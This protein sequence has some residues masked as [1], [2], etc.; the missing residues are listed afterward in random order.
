MGKQKKRENKQIP[1]AMANKDTNKITSRSLFMIGE[2]WMEKKSSLLFAIISILSLVFSLLLFNVRISEGG[3]D[4]TYIE[5]GYKYYKDFFN[6]YFSFNA[7]LYPMFL[8]LPISVFGLNII[9]LKFLSLIFNFFHLFFLYKAFNKR[10]PNFVL[11]PVLFITATNVHFHYFASQTYNE[12]FFLFF[13]SLFFFVFVKLYDSI[14][15]NNSELRKTYKLWLAVGF[16]ALILSLTKNVGIVL[17]PVIILFFLLNKQY[18]NAMYS[19]LAFLCF[20]IPFEIIKF[21]A[22]GNIG[23]YGSQGAILLQ[24]DPYNASKGQEDIS[25]FIGRFFDNIDLYL[26]KRFFQ[27]LGFLSEESLAVSRGMAIVVLILLLWGLFKIFRSKNKILLFASIYVAAFL[28]ASF[29][30]IQARWDQPRYI[31]IL[32]PLMLMIILFGIYCLLIKSSSPVQTIFLYLII[33]LTFAGIFTTF[34]KIKKNLPILSKNIRGDIYYGYTPD[35]TNYLKLSKWCSKNLPDSAYVACRKAPMS[36]IYGN[37]KAFYPVYIVTE[38]HPDS[39]LATF[40]E[41]KVTHI[42]IANLRRNPKKADGYIINTMHRIMQPI[43][44][45]YPQ[46]ITLVRQEGQAEPSYLYQINY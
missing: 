8:S 35:W 32:V 5:A 30:A 40:K 20:K 28:V 27:I 25:G 46:K 15:L 12:S 41:N 17:V 34:G 37:G 33:A 14:E 13:Q 23:Q 43:A 1:S 2:E 7:P 9:V 3:D 44:E 22:W 39:V 24:K 42:L 29:L 16:G 18:L 21:L 45:K 4:S 26:F 6:Y 31:M 38:T 19:A 10:I 11:F 36:F